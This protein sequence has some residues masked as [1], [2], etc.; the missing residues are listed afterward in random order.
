MKRYIIKIDDQHIWSYVV[1]EEDN[2]FSCRLLRPHGG[3]NL[4]LEN[5]DEYWGYFLKLISHVE[6][7]EIDICF[8]YLETARDKFKRI[9]EL[10]PQNQF[11]YPKKNEWKTSELICYFRKFRDTKQEVTFAAKPDRLLLKNGETFVV[12]GL[13]NFCLVNDAD[14][15]KKNNDVSETV[16]TDSASIQKTKPWKK[17]RIKVYYPEEQKVVTSSNVAK[18]SSE[19]VIN[20][21]KTSAIKKEKSPIIKQEKHTDYTEDNVPLE[22]ITAEDLQRHIERQTE[23]Q[24]ETV[25]FR[26]SAHSM[27]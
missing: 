16:D 10:V 26:P 27:Q 17:S 3:K 2:T 7:S 8:L 6:G 25:L 19:S 11:S 18:T 21:E 22:K 24:C 5:S 12:N 15:F 20:K 13:E 4:L 1:D 9:Y 23:G 14:F